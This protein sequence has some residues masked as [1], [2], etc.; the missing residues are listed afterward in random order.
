MVEN[1][2]LICNLIYDYYETRIALGANRYGD[3]LPPIPRI[4]KEFQMAPRTVRAA[5]SQLEEDGY[6][7]VSPRKPAKVIY[8]TDPAL[9]R[10]NA[11]R[12]FVPRQDGILDFCQAGKLI[13]EPVW[14]FAQNRLDKET[15][16][17]LNEKLAETRNVNLPVSTRLYLCVFGAL[18]N[19]LIL[20]FYWELLR[21]I[22]IPYLANHNVHDT[23]D[24]EILADGKENELEFM[25]GEFEGDFGKGI[26][27]LIDFCSRAEEQYGLSEKEKIPFCWNVY[28]QRP[29]LC[30]TYVTRIISEIIK[31]TYPVGSSLPSMT[32]MSKQMNISYRTLRRTLSILDSLGIIRL[33][34]GK[35]T[36][37]CED[38][39]QIDFERPEVKSGFQL[40]RE[41]LQFVALT[42]R[43]V[44]L[45]TLQNV[46]KDACDELVQ[47]FIGMYEQNNCQLCFKKTMDF[48]IEKCPSAAV[49]ECYCRLS[50]F[51]V[52][53]YPFMRYRVRKQCL[54]E[55]YAQTVG[56]AA[57]VLKNG[58]WEGFADLWS[59][60]MK[61][62][63]QKAEQILADYHLYEND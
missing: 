28:W 19:K 24:Q 4:G 52:W 8:R 45:Y 12:Y 31:G 14:E 9:V 48:V 30:Y 59:G 43:P 23:R 41:S 58:D 13:V 22:R 50:D 44:F 60:L 25:K 47:D 56:A 46:K 2:D 37:V 33:H 21:Y 3:L 62:E 17:L 57:V 32:D 35:V 40:Y 7:E 29:Q 18:H 39:P 38:I 1:A 42:V 54:Q 6:I 15:W 27:E 11:A 61:N 5:L 51:L 10:E 63:Q 49:R 55:A 53:G 26:C 36:E 20:N 16:A 34:Q